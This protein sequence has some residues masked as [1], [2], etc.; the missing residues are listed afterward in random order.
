LAAEELGNAANEMDQVNVGCLTVIENLAGSESSLL[1]SRSQMRLG[2]KVHRITDSLPR[3]VLGRALDEK[4]VSSKLL[5]GRVDLSK[6][7]S[8]RNKGNDGAEGQAGSEEEYG[9]DEEEAEPEPIAKPPA[10][11]KRNT[12]NRRR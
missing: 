3:L 7:D 1:G 8:G 2:P 4:A 10:S 12:G 9:L 5:K 6:L 11:K